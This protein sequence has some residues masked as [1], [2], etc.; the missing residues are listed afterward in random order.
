MTGDKRQ[1]HVNDRPRN[2]PVRTSIGMAAVTFYGLLWLAGANDILAERFDISLFATTWFFRVTIFVGPVLAYIITKRI[3]LGLQRKDAESVAHGVESGVIV[4][5]PEG[6]FSE[7]HEP[8]RDEEMHVLLSKEKVRPAAPEKDAQGIPAAK[9]PLGHLRS[10]LNRAWTIDDI[11][12]EAPAH[13]EPEKGEQEAI[14]S[15][16]GSEAKR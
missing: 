14:E 1:H 11:P 9:G 7:R 10:R 6:G 16:K 5:S 4:M 15:G 8:A 2:A 13:G 3:C 12:V